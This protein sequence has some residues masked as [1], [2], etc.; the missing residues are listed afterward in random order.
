M[1]GSPPTSAQNVA[2]LIAPSPRTTGSIMWGPTTAT[3]PT[4]S[5]VA[6]VG[7]DGGL[8]DL[9]YVDENGIKQKENRKV[10]DVFAWGG[11]IVGNLQDTYDRT[12]TFKLL[13]FNSQNTMSVGYGTDNVSLTAATTSAGNELAIQMNAKLLDTMSWVFDG[14]YNAQLCRI[15]IPIGRVISLGEVDITQKSYAAIDCTLKAFPDANRNHGYIYLND[16]V[17]S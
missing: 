12:M 6:L 17:V 8:V 3:L 14:I 16:G 13:Q 11:D 9:G 2:Q 10:T 7:G 4:S 1:T 15:V 5:Y